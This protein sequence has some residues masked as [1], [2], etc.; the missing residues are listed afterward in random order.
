MTRAVSPVPPSAEEHTGSQRAFDEIYAANFERLTL[1]LYAYLG[2]LSEAQDIVQDAFC[3]TYARWKVIHSYADPV[4]WVRRV[5]WNLATS[6]F[7]RQK[8]ARRFLRRQREQHVAGPD[9]DRVAL[10]R[11]LAKLP[12][13]HREAV[14]LHYMAQLSVAEIAVQED[15][16]EG[17]VK[18]WLS[19]GRSAL[20]AQL[21]DT[22]KVDSDA[23]P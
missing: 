3:R 22:G 11:A 9:P 5:A 4:G 20:A 2:D 16:A 19:R 14:V 13:R 7:R 15:V 21:I 8:T 6:H 12:P 23:R 1:Q 18:S 17:T 10:I